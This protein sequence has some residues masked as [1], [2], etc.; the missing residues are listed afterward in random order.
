MGSAFGFLAG[1]LRRQVDLVLMFCK[2]ILL[3]FPATLLAIAI[4][5]MIG[6]GLRNSLFAISLVSIPA[7]A[8]L[9]RSAVLAL[10]EQDFVI[11][12]LSLGGRGRRRVLSPLAPD[13]FPPPVGRTTL[14]SAFA[15]PGAGAA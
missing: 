4:V 12:A 2:A 3:A 7:Y 13:S 10:R 11:A 9:S 15:M 6:P 14:S 5:A 1:Y 8:R